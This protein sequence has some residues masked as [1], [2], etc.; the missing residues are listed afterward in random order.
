MLAVYL[1]NMSYSFSIFA[2]L[3]SRIACIENFPKSGGIE[4]PFAE[5]DFEVCEQ[6]VIRGGDHGGRRGYVPLNI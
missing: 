3:I 1:S 4:S 2:K 5:M 6:S